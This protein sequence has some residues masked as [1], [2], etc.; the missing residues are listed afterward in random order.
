MSQGGTATW[1]TSVTNWDNGNGLDRVAWYNA[2]SDSAI[3]GGTAGTVTLGE[4]ISIRN[5]TINSAYTIRSNTLNFASGGRITNSVANVTIASAITGSPAV[6]ANQ[7][8]NQLFTFAPTVGSVA[9][10]AINA[11]NGPIIVLGG[12]TTMTNSIASDSEGK[13]RMSSGTW[14]LTGEAYAYEHWIQGGVFIIS[15]GTIRHG[16]RAI[17]FTGGTLHYNNPAAVRSGVAA[18][19]L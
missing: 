17:N 13:L 19:L 14:T 11:P 9:L 2:A 12:T 16:K 3:L 10:G 8:A 15:T 7:A 5:L 18:G 4:A 1:S 6:Q